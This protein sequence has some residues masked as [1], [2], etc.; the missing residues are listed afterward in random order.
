VE[1]IPDPTVWW[2]QK[3][4]KEDSTDSSRVASGAAERI[5]NPN[6]W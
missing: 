2:I 5:P 4:L 3:M 1:R 6:F